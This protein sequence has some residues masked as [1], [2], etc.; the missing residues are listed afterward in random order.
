MII[1]IHHRQGVDRAKALLGVARQCRALGRPLLVFSDTIIDAH[2]REALAHLGAKPD[3]LE[4]IRFRCCGESDD[5]ASSSA[6]DSDAM[7]RVA[8]LVFGDAPDAGGA[9]G[10]LDWS[11]AS[12]DRELVVRLRRTYEARSVGTEGPQPTLFASYHRS[13]ISACAM[14]T[15]VGATDALLAA[16]TIYPQCPAWL[17]N[18]LPFDP[19]RSLSDTARFPRVGDSNEESE[20]SEN[21]VDCQHVEDSQHESGSTDAIESPMSQTERLAALGQVAAGAAHEL[22]NPLAIISSSLQYLHQTL[23]TSKD[24]ARDFTTIA[25]Q[26]VDRMHDLLR[27]ML[28]FAVAKK[29]EA[30][31]VDL[32]DALMEVLRFLAVECSRR[33]VLLETSFESALPEIWGDR[34]GIKQV[35][36]N[37]T[38]NALDALA[39]QGDRLVVRTRQTADC[40]AVHVEFENN[41]PRIPD[42]VVPK[43]FRPFQTTKATGIGLGL[44]LS[45]QIAREN[46]GDLEAKNLGNGVRFRVILPVDR[47]RGVRGVNDGADSRC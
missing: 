43:L 23:D 32:N 37:L 27:S 36:L 19:V 12:I 33:S 22:G 31:H 18:L 9:V 42:E 44:Y 21:T 38:K 15:L 24:P 45:R 34:G 11:G 6:W 26:N 13:E 41:G 4:A 30:I 2:T 46:G 28:D 8:A 5:S 39:E 20:A 1:G 40:S 29:P 35:F 17:L 14:A 16:E 7:S 47:R 25:L 3:E 10:W